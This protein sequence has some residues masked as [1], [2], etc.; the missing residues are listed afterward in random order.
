MGGLENKTKRKQKLG[1]EY[2]GERLECTWFGLGRVFRIA[3]QKD[4]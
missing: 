3:T 4:M 1:N 2:S